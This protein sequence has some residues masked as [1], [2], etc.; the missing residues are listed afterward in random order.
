MSLI[1]VRYVATHTL[2]HAQ[3]FLYSELTYSCVLVAMTAVSLDC[4]LLTSEQ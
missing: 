2:Y 4:T 1:H 3:Q